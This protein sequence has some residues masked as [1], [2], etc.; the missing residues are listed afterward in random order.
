MFDSNITLF[1]LME[2]FAESGEV[3]QEARFKMSTFIFHDKVI[4]IVSPL[5]NSLNIYIEVSR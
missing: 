3:I 4:I 2:C 1:G 5:C